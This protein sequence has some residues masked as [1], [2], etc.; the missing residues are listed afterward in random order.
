MDETLKLILANGSGAVAIAAIIWM[1][2]AQLP[3]EREA[4]EKLVDTFIADNRSARAAV[5][6]ATSAARD[7]CDKHTMGI[8]KEFKDEMTREREAHAVAR[9]QMLDLLRKDT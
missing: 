2:I 4:R 8:V 3:K 7:A 6:L 9:Q 5:E 1:V